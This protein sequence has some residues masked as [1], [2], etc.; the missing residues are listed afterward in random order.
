MKN[1]KYKLL[2]TFL[3]VAI[4]IFII[5]YLFLLL[6]GLTLVDIRVNGLNLFTNGFDPRLFNKKTYLE[7]FYIAFSFTIIVSTCIFFKFR[8]LGS[9]GT[10][11]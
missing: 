4:S 3:F 9:N 7:I 2:T 1:K 6:V 11:K 5:T 10:E 8:G